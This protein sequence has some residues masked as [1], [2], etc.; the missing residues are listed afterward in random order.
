MIGLL[1]GRTISPLSDRGASEAARWRAFGGALRDVAKG[2]Q[3]LGDDERIDRVLPYAVAFGV[4]AALA[5]RLHKER[6]ALPGWF[7]A[8]PGEGGGTA[9]V[10][11]LSSQAATGH[12]HGAGGGGGAAGGGSSGAH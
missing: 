5:T 8:L 3:P 10:A 7:Q 2:R 1:L 9:L 6:R 4:G 11:M 12:G